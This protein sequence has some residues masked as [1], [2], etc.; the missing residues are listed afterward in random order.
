MLSRQMQ[1][2][3]EK[4]YSC[5]PFELDQ[6][7]KAR[8]Y[9]P[10]W[11]LSGWGAW[12]AIPKFRYWRRSLLG[13]GV[14][15]EVGPERGLCHSVSQSNPPHVLSGRGEAQRG[16]EIHLGSHGQEKKGPRCCSGSCNPQ[17]QI[18]QLVKELNLE[19]WKTRS[20]A[21]HTP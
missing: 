8:L 11:S 18:R 6:R 20:K 3:P 5:L 17:T 9:D 19:P 15:C 16:W 4:P 12:S 14:L 7:Q 2:H 1:L 13:C 10:L 21:H